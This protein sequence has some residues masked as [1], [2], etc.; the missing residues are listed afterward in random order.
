MVGSRVRTSTEMRQHRAP[1]TADRPH[2]VPPI[3]WRRSFS[4]TAPAVARTQV[5]MV[6]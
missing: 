3:N 6:K 4:Y 1:E 2:P 5:A